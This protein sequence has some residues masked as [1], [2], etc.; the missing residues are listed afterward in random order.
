VVGAP[1]PN[2]A[3]D[4]GPSLELPTEHPPCQLGYFI[5]GRE[6]EANELIGR[7]FANATAQIGWQKALEAD[8][9]F[10]TNDAILRAEWHVPREDDSNE[11]CER[12]QDRPP[13]GESRVADE[14]H[15]N[16]DH[17]DEQYGKREEMERWNPPTVSAERLCLI[18][19]YDSLSF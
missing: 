3:L 7:Q 18:C 16:E 5:V 6:S 1:A 9:L 13:T 10:E 8:P 12:H 14:I 17:V 19:H 11:Q 15:H 2:G 4:V